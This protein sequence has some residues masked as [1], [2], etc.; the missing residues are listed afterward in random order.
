VELEDAIDQQ[1]LWSLGFVAWNLE[2]IWEKERAKAVV[3]MASKDLLRFFGWL[4][5]KEDN[6]FEEISEKKII[7]SETWGA[8]VDTVF[9][10]KSMSK[11]IRWT[12]RWKTECNRSVEERERRSTRFVDGQENSTL[13]VD[14]HVKA[15]G[16]WRERDTPKGNYVG[17]GSIY[18]WWQVKESVLGSFRL[19]W[20]SFSIFSNFL[21][22]DAS[23]QCRDR[24]GVGLSSGHK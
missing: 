3:F 23:K 4:R 11:G 1:K 18:D 20:E 2:L 14:Q 6:G 17:G 16:R 12:S 21:S 19:L 10:E 15:I 8:C 5:N 9:W 24:L 7:Y 22:L 13:T